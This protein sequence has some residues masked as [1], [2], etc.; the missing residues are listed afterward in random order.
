MS[1]KQNIGYDD[2]KKMLGKLR[3]ISE[4]TSSKKTISEQKVNTL[5]I[6]SNVE[7]KIHGDNE[8]NLKI[9]DEEKNSLNQLIENFKT[10]VYELATFDEGIN[11]YK[12]S[13]RMDGKIFDDLTFV[14]IA[15]EDM[16]VYVN[17]SMLKIEAENSTIIEKLYKFEHT[18]QDVAN[19]LIQGRKYN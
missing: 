19:E 12:D 11:V 6:G 4:S 1:N 7:I 10:Q 16:G 13:V 9:S 3:S 18:F 2:I 8:L 14:F 5:V 15:G 17:C